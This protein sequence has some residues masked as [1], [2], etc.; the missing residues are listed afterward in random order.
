MQDAD[1]H[2]QHATPNTVSAKVLQVR[3]LQSVLQCIKAGNKQVCTVDFSSGG[4]NVRWEDE[5]KSLQGSVFMKPE[6]FSEFHAPK[7]HE[8]GLPLH[9]LLD[10]LA[11]F[12]TSD[13]VMGL[14][15][16][17]PN[18]ELVCEAVQ[19]G[20]QGSAAVSTWARISSLGAEPPHDLSD[21]WTD[22]TSYFLLPGALLKEAVEDL[23]WPGG[24]V[25]LSLQ[26]QPRAISLKAR[27]HGTLVVELPMQELSG[28]SVAQPEVCFS[29][30]FKHLRAACCN[31]PHPKE[32]TSVT[33]KVSIDVNGLLKVTHMLTL[34]PA[35]GAGGGRGP[36]VVEHPSAL[37]ES[38]RLNDASRV[39]VVTFMLQP[40]DL[41]GDEDR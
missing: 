23:E 17:G 40:A 15:Y 26:Q 32:G 33:T 36:R 1:R 39:A 21:Y 2:D 28:F 34:G 31:L 9:V 27:G 22:P 24:D 37:L 7:R 14:Y 20:G 29:Y 13:A 38:Q 3:T 30:K 35:P 12:A 41:E 10:T 4:M 18:G 16:P 6:L 8:F 19:G 5:S 25:D 11:V